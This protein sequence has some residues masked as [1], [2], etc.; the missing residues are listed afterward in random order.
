[1]SDAAPAPPG[2]TQ[3]AAA[4]P[5]PASSERE[6]KRRL[7][8]ALRRGDIREMRA[9]WHDPRLEPHMTLFVLLAVAFTVGVFIWVVEPLL[10]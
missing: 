5:A 4:E 2:A 9:L 1:M 10:I 7:T 8:A 3:A 6:F